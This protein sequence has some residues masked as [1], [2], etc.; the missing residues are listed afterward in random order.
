MSGARAN[1][2]AAARRDAVT[3]TDPKLA[4]ECPRRQRAW[5]EIVL[6]DENGVRIPHEEYLITADGSEYSGVL[7]AAGFARVDGIDPGPYQVSFP[8]LDQSEWK[9]K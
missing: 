9:K 5:I 6:E 8:R 4:V 3:A 1:S 2:L 7:D